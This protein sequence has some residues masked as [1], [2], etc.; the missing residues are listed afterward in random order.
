[1]S[2]LS[3]E[4]RDA[5]LRQVR[6]FSSR[7]AILLGGS[8]GESSKVIRDWFFKQDVALHDQGGMAAITTDEDPA[9]TVRLQLR[10]VEWT[11]GTRRPSLT[12]Y[13]LGEDDRAVSYSWT[14]GGAERIGLNLRW[15]Q[16]SCTHEESDNS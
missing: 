14:E 13:V 8:H 5:I 7:V 2:G 16:A 11:Y 3:G 12:L 4:T 1:S 9:R 15:I 10:D 6:P